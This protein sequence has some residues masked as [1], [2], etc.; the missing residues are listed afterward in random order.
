MAFRIAPKVVVIMASCL[1]CPFSMVFLNGVDD[2]GWKGYNSSPPSGLTDCQLFLDSFGGGAWPLLPND[3][4]G[5][6]G[7]GK[8]AVANFTRNE[9]TTKLWPAFIFGCHEEGVRDWNRAGIDI[10]GIERK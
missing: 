9:M 2:V 3:A 6:E 8:M 7:S 5:R 10:E 4:R 1:D